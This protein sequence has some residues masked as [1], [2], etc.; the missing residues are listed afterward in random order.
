QNAAAKARRVTGELVHDRGRTKERPKLR[1]AVRHAEGGTETEAEAE[2]GRTRAAPRAREGV[3][4]APLLRRVRLVA[5]LPAQGVPA[6]ALLG[7]RSP[8]LPA[9]RARAGA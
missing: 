4:A 3:A 2:P 8:W 9:P 5:D 6:A 1:R 7:R